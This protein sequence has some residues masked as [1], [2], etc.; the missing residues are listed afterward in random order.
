MANGKASLS[1]V[2]S[3]RGVSL[4]CSFVIVQFL[5]QSGGKDVNCEITNCCIDLKQPNIIR[6]EPLTH[7]APTL[8]LQRGFEFCQGFNGQDSSPATMA[9]ESQRKTCSEIGL[10][11]LVFAIN[12]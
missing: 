1:V 6:C 2:L 12:I 10:I 8:Q 9:A 5:H 7:H 4:L 11:C 3:L